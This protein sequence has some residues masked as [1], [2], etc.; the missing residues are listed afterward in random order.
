[1]LAD[2]VSR[3]D[4]VPEP[5]RSS[6]L[7]LQQTSGSHDAYATSTGFYCSQ[8]EIKEDGRNYRTD[9]SVET[10]TNET[11]KVHRKESGSDDLRS[12]EACTTVSED[13]ERE[14]TVYY[15]SQADDDEKEEWEDKSTDILADSEHLVE[16]TEVL[17]LGGLGQLGG[18][19]PFK[20]LQ[21]FS[22]PLK[23]NTI[24]TCAVN[25]RS[26]RTLEEMD[27]SIATRTPLPSVHLY[28]DQ[29]EGIRKRSDCLCDL[30]YGQ[31]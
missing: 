11:V 20:D 24:K 13:L 6:S 22:F 18:M 31:S 21:R 10:I 5:Q 9:V 25:N 4:S 7:Q 1:M 30:K 29:Q 26:M 2:S 16:N 28:F 19:S 8:P 14:N 12:I 15:D 27:R 23:F 3:Q 17:S